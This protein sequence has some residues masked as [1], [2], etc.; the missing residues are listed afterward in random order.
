MVKGALSQGARGLKDKLSYNVRNLRRRPDIVRSYFRAS[1]LPIGEG[2]R[3]K[4]LKYCEP[5]EITK[6]CIYE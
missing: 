2:A 1:K 3:Q 6:L 4:L 5:E